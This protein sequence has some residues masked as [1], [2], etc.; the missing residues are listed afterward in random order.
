M[1]SL[2]YKSKSIVR[3]RGNSRAMTFVFTGKGRASKASPTLHRLTDESSNVG[4]GRN[5]VADHKAS[6]QASLVDISTIGS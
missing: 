1:H 6:S 5:A 2:L 3:S 4:P